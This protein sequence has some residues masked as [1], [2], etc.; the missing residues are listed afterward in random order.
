MKHL[1][2]LSLMVVAIAA[3]AAF[4]G[5]SSASAAS[6]LCTS[7]SPTCSGQFAAGDTLTGTVEAGT[8]AKLS[9]IITLSCSASS[10]VVEVTGEGTG[11]VTGATWTSCTP[12]GC[13]ATAEAASLPWSGTYAATSGGNGSLSVSSPKVKVVCGLTCTFTASSVNLA[14][15]QGSGGSEAND[16]KVVASN[17]PLTSA[18]GSGTWNATYRITSAHMATGGTVSNPAVSMQ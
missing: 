17:V 5:V 18:C 9:G 12:S 4:T 6:K 8:Q 16:A 11:K 14:F 15:T 3:M 1:K 10:V 13:T 2:V 7:V